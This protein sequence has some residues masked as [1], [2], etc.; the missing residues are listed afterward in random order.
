M[1]EP[2]VANFTASVAPHVW[3]RKRIV[4]SVAAVAV[5]IACMH[6]RC[7]LHGLFLDDHAHY[8]QLQE[9]GWSLR[10]LTDA[11]RLELVGGVIDVWWLPETTLRFFRPVSFAIMKAIYSVT[12]WQP[13]AMHFV[14]LF[15]H[16]TVCL[17]LMRFVAMVG[18]RP[19]LALGIT[20][21]FAI[22][23]GH[24]ATVQWIASQ[25]EL[26][27]TTF[28]MISALA[29]FDYR[30]W[31]TNKP[32]TRAKLILSLIFFAL[33]TGCRENAV[34][35]PFVLLVGEF[36]RRRPWREI[37]VA[38]A[39]YLAIVAVYLVLRTWMLADA[40]LPPKP[41]VIHP[42]D[43]AFPRFIFDKACYYLVSQFL[44]VPC[45]PFGGVLYFREHPQAF[46][47]MSA[48][49]IAVI[50]LVLTVHRNRLAI[51]LGGAWLFLF[52]LPVLPAFESPHHLYLPGVGW[53]ILGALGFQAATGM[54]PFRESWKSAARHSAAWTIG[55][56]IGLAFGVACYFSALSLDA[57][58]MVEDRVVEEIA[59]AN[60]P[61]REGHTLYVMN[62]PIIA[63]YVR[64][65]VEERLG[66]KNLKAVALTWSPRLLGNQSNTEC[67]PL[68][69]GGVARGLEVRVADDRYFAGP[70]GTMVASALGRP[71][72][73]DFDHP[74]ERSDF[75]V[76]LLAADE[77]GVSGL[78][79]QFAEPLAAPGRHFF[80]GSRTR[81]A[82]QL[83]F[84]EQPAK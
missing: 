16:L 56:V 23:P 30:Q 33:A 55:I 53:A 21:L 39:P 25:T 46:Y 45:I 52:M 2:G 8:R 9:C 22:H 27:V 15:W 71:R 48:G 61:V 74:V 68:F 82:Y 14:S 31:W 59:A 43:P 13:M 44:L 54:R 47:G 70:M 64:L 12:G 24:V 34:M 78:R 60:P 57:A 50:A 1:S 7:I 72:P 63:H 37:L 51:L 18:A 76:E 80:W 4:W 66:L 75:R 32:P 62:L 58:Q 17:L 84:V 36:V 83:R 79:F 69:E 11:C 73:V 35:L 29:Y 67:T 77:L 5:L 10:E 65:G 19:I 20:L 28:L 38:L 81:W 6:G 40:V 26:M 41:Y 49:V 3:S 42:G